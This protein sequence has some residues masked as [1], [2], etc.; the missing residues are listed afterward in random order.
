[1]IIAEVHSWTDHVQDLHTS[2]PIPGLEA[3]DLWCSFV[4]LK[5]K[6]SASKKYLRKYNHATEDI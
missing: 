4:L 5:K 1:M 2:Q 6:I 3:F